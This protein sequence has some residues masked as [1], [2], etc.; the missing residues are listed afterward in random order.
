MKDQPVRDGSL[1]R[2]A[3]VE[4][5]AEVADLTKRGADVV[6]ETVLGTIVE[7]LGREEKVELRGFGSFRLRQRDP[8]RGRNPR[9]GDRVD[10]P[11]RRVPCAGRRDTASARGR[12]K[13][14]GGGA[15]VALRPWLPCSGRGRR[16]Q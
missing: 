3:L 4:Q 2:A 12:K 1:T 13:R 7:A 8:R 9:T 11:P 16:E 14:A 15:N 5:V 10:V 6:V